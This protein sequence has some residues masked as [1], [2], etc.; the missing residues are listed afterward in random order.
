M[1]TRR[2]FACTQ[3]P[4]LPS[5]KEFRLQLISIKA[6]GFQVVASGLLGQFG[7]K[8]LRSVYVGLWCVLL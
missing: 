8:T 6:Y 2:I 7:Y 4:I 3:S 5:L 1:I